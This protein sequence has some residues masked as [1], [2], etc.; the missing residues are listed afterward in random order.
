[1]E[2]QLADQ[3]A[4]YLAAFVLGILAV[5]LAYYGRRK[6]YGE[7]TCLFGML[8]G[9]ARFVLEFYRDQPMTWDGMHSAQIWALAALAG[10]AAL[11]VLVRKYGQAVTVPTR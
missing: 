6:R 3:P 1:M 11:W 4:Q 7:V 8:Y 2:W 5:L 9:G 10:F